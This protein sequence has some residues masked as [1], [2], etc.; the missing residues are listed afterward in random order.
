MGWL[1]A[2][3][4]PAKPSSQAPAQPP[5]RAP[6]STSQ[7]EP[8]ADPEITKFLALIQAEMGGSSKPAQPAPARSPPAPSQQ[9]TA[10]PEPSPKPSSWSSWFSRSSASTPSSNTTPTN[11]VSS[12][13][14]YTDALPPTSSPSATETP[15]ESIAESLLPTTMDC[16]QAFDLAFHCQSPGG[17]WNAIYRYG[18]VRTCSDLW[19]DFWF[20]MR[21]KGYSGPMKEDLI[22]EHY[23]K[24]EHAKYGPGKPSSEDIWEPRERKVEPGTVFNETYEQPDVS[25]AEWQQAEMERLRRIRQGL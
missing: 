19:D 12:R 3:E 4:A 18:S 25:D 2:N 22:R 8:D 7:A 9:P 11:D 6:T 17:Q 24:K 14:T 1:W 23:R 16:R 13:A 5:P 15:T 10:P 20:C 21:S